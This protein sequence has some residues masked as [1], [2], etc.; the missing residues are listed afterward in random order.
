MVAAVYP[1][2]LPNAPLSVDL[3]KVKPAPSPPLS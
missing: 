2:D 1:F 3:K